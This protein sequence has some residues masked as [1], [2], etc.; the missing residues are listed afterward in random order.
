MFFINVFP[1]IWL[2]VSVDIGAVDPITDGGQAKTKDVT[3]E[4]MSNLVF[5]QI[6]LKCTAVKKGRTGNT[7]P[8]TTS[9][10]RCTKSPNH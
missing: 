2:K 1:M 3:L 6:V 4:M 10:L 8:C 5:L 7:C 9:L